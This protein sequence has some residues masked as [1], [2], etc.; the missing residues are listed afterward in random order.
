MIGYS[1]GTAG[2]Y[3]PHYGVLTIAWDGNIKP[4]LL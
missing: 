3:L 1:L 2:I 4:F